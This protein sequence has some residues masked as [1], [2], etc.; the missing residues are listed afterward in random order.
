M[1]FLRQTVPTP[2]NSTN[3]TKAALFAL[4]VRRCLQSAA[5]FVRL[6]GWTMMDIVWHNPGDFGGSQNSPH[7]S[8]FGIETTTVVMHIVKLFLGTIS[9]W[10]TINHRMKTYINTTLQYFTVFLYFIKRLLLTTWLEGL[11][12]LT[13]ILEP[14]MQ[15]PA[16]AAMP[17]NPLIT[18]PPADRHSDILGMSRNALVQLATSS[19]LRN[20]YVLF[21]SF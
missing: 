19:M 7:L 8:L 1:Q 10:I 6:L 17:S 18:C 12:L 9:T 5:S 20:S 11:Q 4:K 13:E 2:A 15:G 3:T 14:G 21:C 16:L